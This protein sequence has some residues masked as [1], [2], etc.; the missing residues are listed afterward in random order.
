MPETAS[1]EASCVLVRCSVRAVRDCEKNIQKAMSKEKVT[2]SLYFTYAW[3]RPYPT[4][5]NEKMYHRRMHAA[6]SLHYATVCHWLKVPVARKN[7]EDFWEK[8][9]SLF[10]LINQIA[11]RG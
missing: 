1:F 5:C 8:C 2:K 7:R 4:D 6:C 3:G 10:A 11:A 9:L